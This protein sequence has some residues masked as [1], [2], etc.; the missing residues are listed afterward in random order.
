[1]FPRFSADALECTVGFDRFTQLRFVVI[2]HYATVSD[3]LVKERFAALKGDE[4]PDAVRRHA[5]LLGWIKHHGAEDTMMSSPKLA[6]RVLEP[7]HDSLVRCYASGCAGSYLIGYVK[8][9]KG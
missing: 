1:M 2:A 8:A 5:P 4:K 9:M 6:A 3:P 7:R